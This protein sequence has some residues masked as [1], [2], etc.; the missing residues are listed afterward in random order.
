MESEED[1]PLQIE[2]DEVALERE[3]MVPLEERAGKKKCTRNFD[4]LDCEGCNFNLTR[5]WCYYK[6]KFI[7]NTFGVDEQKFTNDQTGAKKC[8]AAVKNKT[9]YSGTGGLFIREKYGKVCPAPPCCLGIDKPIVRGDG[10]NE[11][12][13]WCFK[14]KN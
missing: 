3:E 2:I 13:Y 1:M 7:T 9:F 11:E 14:F 12:K 8:A 5:G 10:C 4:L 6:A